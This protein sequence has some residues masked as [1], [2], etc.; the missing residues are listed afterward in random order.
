LRFIYPANRKVI[1]YLRSLGDEI[2]LCVANLSRSAQAV[3][4]DLSDWRG[5]QPVELLGRSLFPPIGELPYMLTLQGYSFLWFELLPAA[6]EATSLRAT[7]PEFFTLV[8]PHGWPDLFRQPNLAQLESD[9]IPGF[10]P[11]QRW[12]AAKDQRV[13]SA[14]VLARGE[15]V[16]PVEEGPASEKFL[17]EVV[18]AHLAGGERH[19]YFLPLATVW[20]SADAELRP[21]VVRATGAQLRTDA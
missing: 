7:P 8:L 1:A 4:L 15:V 20:W 11:R 2:V 21:G 12:F 16:R 10:L 3:E 14:S 18:E 17:A 5:R 9:V 19:R 13:K 6:A